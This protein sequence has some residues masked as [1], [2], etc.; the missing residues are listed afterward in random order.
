MQVSISAVEKIFSNIEKR[1]KNSSWFLDD[2]EIYSEGAY[3]QL[4][5]KTGTIVIKMVFIS[6]HIV[7]KNN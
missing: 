3:I 2:W 5:K 1:M 6:K 7:A 4:Y